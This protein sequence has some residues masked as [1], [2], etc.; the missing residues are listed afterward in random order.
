MHSVSLGL[1]AAAAG[2]RERSTDV[3]HEDVYDKG[4]YYNFLH[5]IIYFV[6]QKGV[7]SNSMWKSVT[8]TVMRTCVATAAVTPR[9][10]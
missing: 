2:E 6:T 1:P 7:C 5:A 3:Q 4:L 10:R 8:L 9:D